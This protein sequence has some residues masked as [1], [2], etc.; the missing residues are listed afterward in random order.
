MF[1]FFNCKEP[2]IPG[3]MEDVRV[4]RIKKFFKSLFDD[5]VKSRKF[6]RIVI[7]VKTGIQRF[8]HVTKTLDIGFHRGDDFL[9]GPHY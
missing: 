4:I 2:D 7:P 3:W 6:R 1:I 5:L 8:Q 9:R